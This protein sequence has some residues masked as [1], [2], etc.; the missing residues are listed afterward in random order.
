MHEAAESGTP[1]K[2]G[3]QGSAR[4]VKCREC[5]KWRAAKA[6]KCSGSRTGCP[7]ALGEYYMLINRP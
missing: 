7:I 3:R 4:Q 6:G 2:A 1:L 5:N